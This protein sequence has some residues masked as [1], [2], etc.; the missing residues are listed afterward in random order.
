MMELI[1]HDQIKGI[2]SK[3][4][5]MSLQ[6]QRID[7]SIHTVRLSVLMLAVKYPMTAFWHDLLERFFRLIQNLFPVRYKQ[8]PLKP[9]GEKARQI[10][11][12][13]QSP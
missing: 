1:H 5:P 3:H 10:G 8:N 11:F 7:R 12:Q 9:L 2:S 13:V 4:I 6:T